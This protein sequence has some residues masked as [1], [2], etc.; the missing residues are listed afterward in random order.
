MTHEEIM[1][2]GEAVRDGFI[3]GIVYRDKFV[4][5]EDRLTKDIRNKFGHCR[6]IVGKALWKQ[7]FGTRRCSKTYGR[8]NK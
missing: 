7:K 4:D 8:W 5:L 1:A 3:G 6:R 2:C